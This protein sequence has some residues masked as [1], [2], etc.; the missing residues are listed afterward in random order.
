[1]SYNGYGMDNDFGAYGAQHEASYLSNGYGAY[2]EPLLTTVYKDNYREDTKQFQQ[3][4]QNAGFGEFLGSKGVDGYF[5]DKTA[6]ATRQYQASAG[7]PQ[8]GTATQETWDAL[9]AGRGRR[10]SGEGGKFT[11]GS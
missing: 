7:L 4:L 10:G 8:T 3:L 5:G 2:G 11:A 6:N 1:M 9:Q